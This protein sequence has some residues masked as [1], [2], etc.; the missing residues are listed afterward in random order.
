MPKTP[1]IAGQHE[2][3]R[4]WGRRANMV[5]PLLVHPCA[6][7]PGAPAHE[8]PMMMGPMANVIHLSVT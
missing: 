1:A 6:N 5:E 3:G 2:G 7:A 4:V 8:V